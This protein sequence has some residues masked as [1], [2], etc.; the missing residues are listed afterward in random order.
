MERG[1]PENALTISERDRIMTEVKQTDKMVAGA[2]F[3]IRQEID[4]SKSVMIFGLEEKHESNHQKRQAYERASI[5][6]LLEALGFEVGEGMIATHTRIGKYKMYG[7][8]VRPIKLVLGSTSTHRELLQRVPSLRFIVDL[9]RVFVRKDMSKRERQ[10]SIWLK[11]RKE[12]SYKHKTRAEKGKFFWKD[13]ETKGD[14][15]T[16]HWVEPAG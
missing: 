2:I 3:K 13:V 11:H 4:R 12:G 16:D 14:W 7:P 8:K 15:L 5:T 9:Q 10:R 1:T 6:R